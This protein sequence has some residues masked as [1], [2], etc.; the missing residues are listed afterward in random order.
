MHYLK[1]RG[2]YQTV[3]YILHTHIPE[4]ED[5]EGVVILYWGK[6]ST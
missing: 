1:S 5:S 2:G 4:G 3:K 6:Y